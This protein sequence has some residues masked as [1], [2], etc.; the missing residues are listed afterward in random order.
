M[1]RIFSVEFHD[2]I[3]IADYCFVCLRVYVLTNTANYALFPCVETERDG[4]E[5]STQCKLTE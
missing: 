5:F 1:F 2:R 4:L 3:Y